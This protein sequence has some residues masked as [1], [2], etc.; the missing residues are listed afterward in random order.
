MNTSENYIITIGRELGS[1]GRSIGRIL[2]GKLG[3]NFYDKILVEMLVKEFDLHVEEIEKIKARKKNWWSEICQKIAPAPTID[4][5]ERISEMI[6]TDEIYKAETKILKEICENE[7]CVIAG[8]S[9]FFI[10]KNHPNKLSI[11]IRASREHRIKRV[12]ERQ[13]LSEKEA[14]ATIERVDKGRE[15]YTMRYTGVSRYDA[16]NYDL[17]LNV[18]NLS[19]EAAADCIIDFIN[20]NG[21]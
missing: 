1:G 12:M 3:I 15:N 5:S 13:H 20:K 2:A 7:S 17:V 14:I 16:R 19:D 9:G 11:F 18:D 4:Y 6:T 10:F 8:R 21:K